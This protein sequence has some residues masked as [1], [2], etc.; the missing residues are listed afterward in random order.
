MKSDVLKVLL[1]TE[2]K[3]SKKKKP[4]IREIDKAKHDM[5]VKLWQLA[6]EY[7]QGE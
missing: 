5:E 7:E 3:K 2:K 1:S 6:E 4:T